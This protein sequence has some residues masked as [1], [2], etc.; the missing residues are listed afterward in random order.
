VGVGGG[1]YYNNFISFTIKV[2]KFLFKVALGKIKMFLTAWKM[3][4]LGYTSMVGA[5]PVWPNEP[6]WWGHTGMVPTILVWSPTYRYGPQH[7]GMAPQLTGMAPTIPVH[8]T[9]LVWPLPY[10][11]GPHHTGR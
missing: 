11:Y 5:I 3:K 1:Y 9:I 7:T 2:F 8:W 6:V 4:W 10:R